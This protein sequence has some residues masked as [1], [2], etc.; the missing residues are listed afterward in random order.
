MKVPYIDLQRQA[1]QL[2]AE[3]LEELAKVVDECTFVLG[4]H[5]S[6][7]E[8]EFAKYLGVKHC[9]AVNSGTSALHLA[10]RVLDIGPGDEVITTPFTFVATAWAIAYVG[11]KPIFVDVDP[12]TFNIDPAAVERAITPRTRA[13]IVVHLFGLP[14]DMD[15]LVKIC[16]RYGLVLVEDAA[17]AHGA[18]YGGRMI[19]TFGR[20]ACFS[21]YPT[22]NLGAIGEGGALVTDEPNIAVRARSLR[23][24]GSDRK[25]HHVEVG[26]NY[27]MEGIQG[28]ILK[29]KLKY[30]DQWNAERARLARLYIDLLSDTP[31]TLPRQNPGCI[32]VW[33][34]FTV[35]CN[36]RD[37]LKRYLEEHGV[38]TAIHYP[39]PLHLQP[40]F[41]HLGYKPG[42]LPVAEQ[43]SRE[44]LSLP[45]YPGLT[46]EEVKFVADTIRK[47]F[48]RT[49]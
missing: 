41:A 7:F 37:E 38:G 21:F 45:L 5:V 3:L 44:C 26:Y 35:R 17:Q 27:R 34:L 12:T 28:A 39:I 6:A 36:R 31:L 25:Y 4:P 49:R 33:H 42:D 48:A 20:V 13:I 30:L 43:L 16:D 14:C 29:V 47:F 32:P 15:A 9:V 11:A 22:K 1:A 24:H 2:R 46:E 40:A 18:R 8:E 10:L 19:G 23:D